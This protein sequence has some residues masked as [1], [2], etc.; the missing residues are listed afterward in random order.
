MRIVC[1][2]VG[3]KGSVDVAV[4][5]CERRESEERA[6]ATHRGCPRWRGEM[7]GLVVGRLGHRPLPCCD[8]K[9]SRLHLREGQVC[10]LFGDCSRIF[11][12]LLALLA[13][14]DPRRPRL[15]R[16]PLR[17][18]HE[19]H[20]CHCCCRERLQRIKALFEGRGA[21]RRRQARR[22]ARRLPPCKGRVIATVPFGACKQQ[23]RKQ[24]CAAKGCH[25]PPWR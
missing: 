6:R 25:L 19:L 10:A 13:D 12:A 20:R 24:L 18:R 21:D 4:C 5:W 23:L 17:R 9:V 1:G 7:V 8:N 3:V 2:C 22:P 14:V 11:H 15:R 16:P